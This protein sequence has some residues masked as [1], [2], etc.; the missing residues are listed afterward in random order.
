[1]NDSLANVTT[2]VDKKDIS[3]NMPDE[4]AN[5]LIQVLTTDPILIRK[6]DGRYV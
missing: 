5:T 6:A 3:K 2:L 4:Q 1:M